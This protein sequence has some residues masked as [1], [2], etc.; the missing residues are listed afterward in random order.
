MFKLYGETIEFQ[1]VL[2]SLGGRLIKE[3]CL[4]DRFWSEVRQRRAET[5]FWMDF[6]QNLGRFFFHYL[7]VLFH[8]QIGDC[9]S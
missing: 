3:N 9:A 2:L 7:W 8:V 5:C 4:S 1:T 6:G